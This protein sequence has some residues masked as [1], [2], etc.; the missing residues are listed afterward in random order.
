SQM[1]ESEPENSNV[2][3]SKHP[4]LSQSQERK[5]HPQSSTRASIFL[6]QSIEQRCHQCIE[7]HRFRLLQHL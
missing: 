4:P 1:D 2:A 3:A 7:V 5:K 6:A